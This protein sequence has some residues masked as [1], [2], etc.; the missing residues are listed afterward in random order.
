MSTISRKPSECCIFFAEGNENGSIFMQ[1][2]KVMDEILVVGPH[3]SIDAFL[4]A[5]KG[6]LELN[7]DALSNGH[8]FLGCM[9]ARSMDS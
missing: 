8:T 3:D 2:A 4:D 7:T 1:V 5:L 9:I 6:L